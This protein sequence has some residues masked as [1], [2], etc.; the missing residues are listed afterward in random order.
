MK[1]NY[2]GRAKRSRVVYGYWNLVLKFLMISMTQ[3]DV[4]RTLR[5]HTQRPVIVSGQ[6]S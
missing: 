5:I 2:D 3:F 1:R 4:S 6:T